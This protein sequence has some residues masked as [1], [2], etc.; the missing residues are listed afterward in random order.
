L[1]NENRDD[2]TIYPGEA[3]MKVAGHRI[4]FI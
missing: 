4:L 1:F 2:L 3:K